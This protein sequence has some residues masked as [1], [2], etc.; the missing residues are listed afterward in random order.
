MKISM[1]DIIPSK[2]V[3]ADKK[4]TYRELSILIRDFNIWHK[5]EEVQKKI[6]HMALELLNSVDR[7]MIKNTTMETLKKNI[8]D[9]VTKAL[10][11]TWENTDQE[12]DREQ[13]W[14]PWSCD[15]PRDDEVY[16]INR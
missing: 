9:A 12:Y 3:P 14:W 13:Q 2:Y 16:D 1:S 6:A 4:D 8:W 5:S 10:T 15:R 7:P 11:N